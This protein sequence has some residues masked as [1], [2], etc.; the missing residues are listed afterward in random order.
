MNPMFDPNQAHL[1]AFSPMHSTAS[2]A[3]FKSDYH[4]Y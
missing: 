2:V 1:Q 3:P 4:G